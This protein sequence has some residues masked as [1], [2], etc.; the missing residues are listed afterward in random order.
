[1]N[2]ISKYKFWVW[3]LLRI[4][5]KVVPCRHAVPVIHWP[6]HMLHLFVSLSAKVLEMIVVTRLTRGRVG[7]CVSFAI[8]F[9]AIGASLIKLG[10]KKVAAWKTTTTTKQR[11]RVSSILVYFICFFHEFHFNIDRSIVKPFSSLVRANFFMYFPLCDWP[12][13]SFVTSAVFAFQGARFS[14][15]WPEFLSLCLGGTV[16]ILDV[17]FVCFYDWLFLVIVS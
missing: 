15:G 4:L 12:I 7:F 10:R 9:G 17:V 11:S 8:S 2:Q 5:N 16:N 14:S 6:S 3:T 1:M 13:T